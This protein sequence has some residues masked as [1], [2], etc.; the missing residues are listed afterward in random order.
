M[1]LNRT[2][3]GTSYVQERMLICCQYA[4][5]AFHMAWPGRLCCRW[6]V[7]DRRRDIRMCFF[8]LG[9]ARGFP[10]DPRWLLRFSPAHSRVKDDR[11]IP[12]VHNPDAHLK[13][14][15]SSLSSVFYTH[16]AAASFRVLRCDSS[17]Q[18]RRSYTKRF[19]RDR[20]REASR[21]SCEKSNPR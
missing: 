6:M 17:S 13:R 18:Q 19:E 10:S 9:R 1:I 14:L 15:S 2:P 16:P 7:R 8:S 20:F 12:N 4:I 5:A 3:W 11:H 21:A